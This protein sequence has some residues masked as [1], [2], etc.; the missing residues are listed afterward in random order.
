MAGIAGCFGSRDEKTINRMLDALAH[1]GPN[2]RRIHSTDRMVW[3]HTRLAIADEGS[4]HQ[5]ILN[6]DRSKG[7][8]ASGAIYNFQTIRERLDESYPFQTH[9]G[10]EVILA[11]Y[12][13]RGP[14]G[15]RDLDGIFAFALFDTE[16]D[17]FMLARDPL[18]I[19]PLYYGYCAGTIYFASER[20]ALSLAGVE[21]VYEF[22]PGHYYT[23]TD[24]FIRY[25]RLPKVDKRPLL[26]A[27]SIALRIRNI[28]TR[29][30]KKRVTSAVPQ[31]AVGALCSGDFSSSIV[32]ALAA[33]EIPHL[34][35][36]AVGMRDEEGNESAELSAARRLAAHVGTRHHELVVSQEMY[37]EALHRVIHLQESYDPDVI[38][39]ALSCYLLSKLAADHVGVVLTGEGAD[40]LFGGHHYMKGFSVAK[41]NEEC[42]RSLGA[43]RQVNLQSLG[44]LARYFDLEM[45]YPFM[46][47]EMI[48]L[49]M[50][51]SA[52]LKIKELDDG[53]KISKWIFRH[54]FADSALLPEEILQQHMAPPPPQKAGWHSF[55]AARAEREITDVELSRLRCDNPGAEIASKEAA[56]YF[57]ILRQGQ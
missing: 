41:V 44:Q 11:L 6:K 30:V 18:G 7:V 32:V 46:D 42:R 33:R 26:N 48:S 4:N 49:S 53:V 8:I 14:D 29:S 3:G 54:A 22:P 47:K 23:P 24:G 1:Q 19:K 55:C 51:I 28:L 35:T 15:V 34:H 52:A 25:Y 12:D 13:Q 27:P 50:K 36:F 38:R 45:R 21:E 39:P 17:T 16:R 56:L 40:E 5:P 37:G 10:A 9:S 43:I 20:T 31:G 2:D 57:K